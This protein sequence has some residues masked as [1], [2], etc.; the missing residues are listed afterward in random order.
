MKDFKFFEKTFVQQPIHRT[1]VITSS[2]ETFARFRIDQ[3]EFHRTLCPEVWDR[4]SFT[5]DG[6]LYF[7]V[8]SPNDLI[9]R[10]FD[11]Y[12]RLHDSQIVNGRADIMHLLHLMN[13]HERF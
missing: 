13:A 3:Y 11:Y 4:R 5:V 12:V 2:M 9:G 1:A 7:A 10:R 8:T 6:R